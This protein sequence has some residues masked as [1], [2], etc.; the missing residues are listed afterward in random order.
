MFFGDGLLHIFIKSG[1]WLRKRGNMKSEGVKTE[2]FRVENRKE[3]GREASENRV[4]TETVQAAENGEPQNYLISETARLV[5]V[6]SHVLRYW[7]EE[8]KLPI[9][10]NELGHRYYTGEDV[11]QFREI[12]KLKEQGLQLK[13]IRTVLTDSRLQVL[14][15]LREKDTFAAGRNTPQT[16]GGSEIHS[17]KEM[18]RPVEELPHMPSGQE[19]SETGLEQDDKGLRLQMLLHSMIS[20]AVRENNAEL[21]GELKET[22]MK[23]MDY[24]F[25]VQEE[26]N[27]RREQERIERDEEHYR[28]LDELLRAYSGR[29]PQKGRRGRE[30]EK[31]LEKGLAQKEKAAQ[32]ENALQKKTPETLFPQKE[33]Q[34]GG[35]SI[36]QQKPKKPEGGDSAVK[37]ERTGKGWIFGG[38]KKKEA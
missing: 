31:A 18:M 28:R 22:I 19:H 27:S 33:A 8:L 29:R 35:V 7:E 30:K 10:R 37:Q 11:E 2:K 17:C 34:S 21:V 25:R 15:P 13:A 26:E 14:V 4:K 16:A 32:T 1:L 12:K 38:W 6:E 36:K 5:G 9:R 24:Q 23:E 20:Q 3:D